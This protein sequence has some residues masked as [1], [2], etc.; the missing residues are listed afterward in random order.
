MR[1]TRAPGLTVDLSAAQLRALRWVN[2]AARSSA[3]RTGNGRP[4]DGAPAR[5]TMLALMEAGLIYS[6][7]DMFT[8]EFV[9]TMSGLGRDVL[10]AAERWVAMRQGRFV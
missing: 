2:S 10:D 9:A 3:W 1:L 6:H 7:Q 4:V 5:R 8:G